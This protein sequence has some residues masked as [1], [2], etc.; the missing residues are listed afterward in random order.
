MTE[1]NA[2]VKNAGVESDSMVESATSGAR[3]EA[4]FFS[5]DG[6]FADLRQISVRLSADLLLGSTFSRF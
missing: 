3:S 4:N 1:S 6:L 5:K 2:F